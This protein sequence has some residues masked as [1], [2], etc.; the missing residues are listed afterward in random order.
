MRIDVVIATCNRQDLITNTL[1][2]LQANTIQDFQAWI[3][4]QSDDSATAD[5]VQRFAAQ[6]PRFVYIHSA[7]KG[8]NAAR[9]IGIA[10][11]VAPIVALTDDDCAVEKNWLEMLLSEYE[12]YPECVSLFGRIKPVSISETAV[13]PEQF[14]EIQRM[15]EIL[16]MAAKDCPHHHMFGDN[17]F[18]LGFG[19]GANMSFRRSAFTTYGLFDEFLGAGAPLCSW[20]ERDI[21][22]RIMAAGGKIL[23]SPNVL[24]YHAH[25]R[26]WPDVRNT[27]RNYA[28]GAGAAVNKYVRTGDWASLRLLSDWIIQMGFRQ[29]LSGLFKW[30]S[31][32]KIYVGFLQLI[33]PWV[34]LWRSRQYS[35]DPTYR[36]YI[37]KKGQTGKAPLLHP[38][39]KVPDL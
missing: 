27:F 22:Y 35:I 34:G 33:Y 8:V 2:S 13:P 9:N 17:R 14:Q 4:D 23:Y 7:V 36:V 24:V 25:W 6:D 20:P 28:Y 39:P 31:W 19:H 12:A 15:Q 18:N 21:G 5:V 37:G 3:V 30:Q 38:P 29:I 1:R 11:G 32:Q 16:P 26:N 10:A